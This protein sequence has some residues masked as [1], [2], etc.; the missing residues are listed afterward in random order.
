VADYCAAGYS[1]PFVHI[2]LPQIV[3]DGGT[4]LFRTRRVAHDSQ[5]ADILLVLPLQAANVPI[6]GHPY[7]APYEDVRLKAAA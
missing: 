1:C 5:H 4:L 3:Q 6:A 7:S 2:A